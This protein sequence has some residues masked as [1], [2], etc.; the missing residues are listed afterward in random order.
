[1]P[2]HWISSVANF[3]YAMVRAT[4]PRRDT[5]FARV[6]HSCSL[7]RKTANRSECPGRA[8]RARAGRIRLLPSNAGELNLSKTKRKHMNENEIEETKQYVLLPSA[9]ASAAT[10]K[11]GDPTAKTLCLNRQRTTVGFSGVRR[12]LWYEHPTERSSDLDEQHG[13]PMTGKDE[14]QQHV[15][16]T[17]SNDDSTPGAS[18]LPGSGG[19]LPQQ[20]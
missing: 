20:I 7:S 4:G 16:K 14:K 6:T 12:H 1:M 13:Q 17:H 18:Q 19:P 8:L 2:R 9:A 10:E 15:I 11:E 3:A 5:P